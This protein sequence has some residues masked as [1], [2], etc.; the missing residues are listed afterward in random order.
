MQNKLYFPNYSQYQLLGCPFKICNQIRLEMDLRF[1]LPNNFSCTHV[2]VFIICYKI[3]FETLHNRVS[4]I[5]LKFVAKIQ[6]WL[7]NS[8]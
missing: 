3:I 8:S 2:E 1:C 6:I 5:A 4:L 7:V